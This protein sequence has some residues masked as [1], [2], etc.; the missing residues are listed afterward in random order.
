MNKILL[1]I[2]CAPKSDQKT[3]EKWLKFAETV[4]SVAKSDNGYDILNSGTFL[5][6]AIDGL[7]FLGHAI[8]QAQQ[9]G[10]SYRVLFLEES[11]ELPKSAV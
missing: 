7:S 8:N 3:L 2:T 6:H 1:V 10:F 9:D 5:I 11:S 4:S